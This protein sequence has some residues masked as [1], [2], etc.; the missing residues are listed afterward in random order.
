MM[1]HSPAWTCCTIWEKNSERGKNSRDLLSE[2][3][4]KSLYIALYD[5]Q[6]PL[7]QGHRCLL[8]SEHCVSMR[9]DA[10]NAPLSL[11]LSF[12]L[13]W[14]D[15]WTRAWRA[16]SSGFPFEAGVF[17]INLKQFNLQLMTSYAMTL[18]LPCSPNIIFE[19]TRIYSAFLHLFKS[20]WII[21]S[22]W[23]IFC[24]IYF[25]RNDEIVICLLIEK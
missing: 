15:S 21:L 3:N 20:I 5:P 16:S 8:V 18:H 2:S 14:H 12:F 10:R 4:S 9:V 25:E 22:I 17:V 19:N 7:H 6:L 13:S 1:R 24:H 23:K 11:F